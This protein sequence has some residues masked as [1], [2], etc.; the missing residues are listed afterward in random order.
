MN[1]IS[2]NEQVPPEN[3]NLIVLV[4]P[5]ISDKEM[6]HQGKYPVKFRVIEARYWGGNG[7]ISG[8]WTLS[9]FG[10]IQ[11]LELIKGHIT[12]WC[13]LP[14]FTKKKECCHCGHDCGNKE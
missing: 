8:C 6:V 2:V 7:Y 3:K 5:Q 13:P 11:D 14:E 12:H 9:Y 10:L 1:W 4:V